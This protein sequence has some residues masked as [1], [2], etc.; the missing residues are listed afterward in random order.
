VSTAYTLDSRGEIATQLWGKDGEDYK[1]VLKDSAAATVYTIDAI[2]T[3]PHSR[4]ATV[5]FGA[6]DATPSVAEGSHFITADGTTL[7]DFDDGQVGD[8]I[9]IENG[10]TACTV[11]QNISQ[12]VLNGQTSFNM[13]GGDTLTLAMFVDQVWQEVGRSVNAALYE[14]VTSFTNTLTAAETGK[15]YFLNSAGGGSTV[16]P[17]PALGLH[18]KF[19][20]ATAPTTAYTID[21]ASGDNIMHGTHI[22]IVGELEYGTAR[23]ILSFVANTSK[24]G[25]SMEVVSDG[26]SWFYT[27]QSG[28]DGGI[29]TGQT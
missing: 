15:T 23:D 24:V 17:S 25:D 29:T 5:T 26:T 8:V 19:I 4:R 18:Y 12:L 27:A 28:A 9:H 1:V 7:T 16:L 13:R 3:P 14:S 20:V 22:D 10:G 21:T 11:T 6:G 2:R